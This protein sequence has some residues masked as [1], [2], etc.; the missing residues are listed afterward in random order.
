MTTS[1]E[2]YSAQAD[3]WEYEQHWRDKQFLINENYDCCIDVLREI[4]ILIDKAGLH[5]LANGVELG[6][7]S[8]CGKMNA[9]IE[10]AKAVLNESEKT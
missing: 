10:R 4:V 1:N 2:D 9:Q 6:S 3:Y 5:N 7:R 8:W